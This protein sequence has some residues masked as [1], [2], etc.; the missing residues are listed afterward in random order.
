[1]NSKHALL[2]LATV[3]AVALTACGGAKSAPQPAAVQ[4]AA[5]AATQSSLEAGVAK[6]RQVLT[7]TQKAV[8]AGDTAKAQ[9]DAKAVDEAWEKFEDQVRDKSKDLYAKIEDQLQLIQAATK[10]S[11]V[12][13]KVVGEAVTKLNGLLDDLVSGKT[14]AA[15][16]AASGLK[17]GVAEM[18]HDLD[19]AQKAIDAGDAAKAQQEATE[20]DEA[21]EKFEDQVKEKNKDLYAKAEDQLH[22]IMAAVKASPL[23]AKTATAAIT[24]LNTYLDRVP[25]LAGDIPAGVAWLKHE[26]EGTNSAVGAGDAVKA[27]KEAEEADQAWESFEDQVKVKN[28]DLYGKVEE[29]LQ[30]LQAAVKPEQIDT[31]L[32]GDIAGK[33][34]RLLD[35]L[36]K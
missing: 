34:S 31:K 20:A 6:M 30:A 8:A 21:W 4:P 11:P 25:A 3:S 14:D 13:S 5:V 28:K 17:A 12:D 26:V 18:K 19:G 27:R 32:V 9:L 1:M 16:N 24:K 36:V 29:Q 15:A 22:A 35:E 10:A 33:L 7:D 23:D 2:A